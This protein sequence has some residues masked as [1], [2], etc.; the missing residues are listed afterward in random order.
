MNNRVQEILAFYLL[1]VY[2]PHFYNQSGICHLRNFM[3]M[4]MGSEKGNDRNKSITRPITTMKSESVCITFPE[5]GETHSVVCTVPPPSKPHSAK[6]RNHVPTAHSKGLRKMMGLEDTGGPG[7]AVTKTQTSIRS[8]T[9][10]E[11]P[12][13]GWSSELPPEVKEKK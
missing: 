1:G 9:R 5:T 13:A 6:M 12:K 7:R 8:L 11:V 2:E 3:Q 4:Q 10:A